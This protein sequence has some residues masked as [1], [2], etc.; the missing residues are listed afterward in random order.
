MLISRGSLRRRTVSGALAALA[1]TALSAAPAS[2]QTVTCTKYVTTTGNDLSDGNSVA[3]AYR[4]PQKLA[5][6]LSAGQTGC[7][8]SGDYAG[9][10]GT[11][12]SEYSLNL[13]AG[14]AAGNP[15]TIRSI[16][17]QRATLKGKVEIR[18]GANNITLA[19]LKVNDTRG[20]WQM[21]S[22]DGNNVTVEDSDISN[23]NALYS[24]MQIGRG[25]NSA[26]TVG[27]IIR[28]N[29]FH[30][31]GSLASGNHDHAIYSQHANGP[32]VY[33]NLFYTT[34]AYALH[35]YP[36]SDYGWW[37]HNVIDGGP[38]WASGTDT[39]RGGIVFGGERTTS[40]DRLSQ[41]NT[42]EFNVVNHTRDKD[43]ISS[44]WGT[45]TPPP[46]SSNL[47]AS[48]CSWDWESGYRS[49]ENPP[50]GFTASGNIEAS[51]LFV[52]RSGFDFRLGATSGCHAI[53]RYDTAARLAAGRET[54]AP[55]TSGNG[56]PSGPNY[57]DG[58]TYTFTSSEGDST[59]ACARRP[60]SGSLAPVDTWALCGRTATVYRS[61]VTTVCYAAAVDFWGN[62]DQS[63]YSYSCPQPTS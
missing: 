11:G 30:H 10:S 47:A 48:N 16:P 40:G 44:S 18:V 4:N 38:D 45:A 61:A 1:C 31:C 35:M 17:G 8:G 63:P 55:D 52:N 21:M 49:I 20:Q 50:I 37:A 54:V 22:I 53:V 58:T 51:P 60:V 62:R 13:S 2:A 15:I 26:P 43:G 25:G 14:G 3:T 36:N 34:S 29:R 56:M 46:A 6:T 28:R 7:I 5:T 9:T 39:F 33:N 27:T 12:G 59:F 57:G 42:V 23:G 24:C 32:K 19:D 41:G